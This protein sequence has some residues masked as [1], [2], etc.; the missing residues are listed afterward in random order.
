MMTKIC[1]STTALSPC[2]THHNVVST[3]HNG[4]RDSRFNT[5]PIMGRGSNSRHP[6]SPHLMM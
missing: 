1:D 2:P 6:I 4:G 3:L 5:Y